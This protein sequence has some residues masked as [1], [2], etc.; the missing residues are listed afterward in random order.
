MFYTTFA[1]L[2]FF[3]YFNLGSVSQVRVLILTLFSE[4]PLAESIRTTALQVMHKLLDLNYSKAF[5][6][7][8]FT[9]SFLH[10]QKV[11]CWQTLCVLTRYVTQETLFDVCEKLFPVFLQNNQTDVRHLC[12]L[13]A[14]AL[15]IRF[16]EQVIRG[17]IFP[18]LGKMELRYQPTAS[19]LIVLGYALHSL[20]ESQIHLLRTEVVEPYLSFIYYFKKI[21]IK[22]KK[23]YL[24]PPFFPL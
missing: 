10:R 16:P 21:I 4:L 18:N 15:T 2:R 9:K 14:I 1:N 23:I 24:P 6:K 19:L 13:C 3:F 17:Y 11:R 12:E 20:S 7:A 22:K 5:S 8:A